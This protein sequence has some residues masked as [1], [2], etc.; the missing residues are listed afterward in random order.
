M[1]AGNT[2]SLWNV[3]DYRVWF[4]GDT[5]S[6]IGMFISSFAM[7]LLAFKVT[8][9]TAL[10]GI[11]S[12][13]ETAFRAI[14]LLFGG[15]LADTVN[16]RKLMLLAACSNVAVYAVLLL[17]W[18][19]GGLTFSSLVI[20]VAVKGILSGV[21]GKITN[22]ILPMIVPKKLLPR[23]SSANQTR[24]AAIDLAS[25]PVG[26]ALF[27]IL[28]ILPFVISFIGFMV[29]I[30]AALL[31]RTN[32]HPK[33][34]KDVS[35]QENSGAAKQEEQVFKKISAGVRWVFSHNIHRSLFF[36]FFLFNIC[37]IGV[38]TSV[39][40]YLVSMGT[41]PTI[42]GIVNSFLS[43]GIMIGGFSANWLQKRMVGGKIV[44]SA[45]IWIVT[46]VSATAISTNYWWL[47]FILF[48]ASLALVP[49][50]SVLQSYQT[51]RTP[52]N[53]MGRMVSVMVLSSMLAITVGTVVSGFLLQEVGFHLTIIIFGCVGVMSMVGTVSSMEIRRIPHEKDLESVTPLD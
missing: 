4:L 8:E 24:D 17:L 32:L 7:V 41:N 11:I 49:M 23:A 51:L 10:A 20:L 9:D 2:N 12:A 19:M 45:V 14:S 27:G 39:N 35:H 44:L 36:I 15:V 16:R 40:L 25:G 42:I 47:G 22:V 6:E 33:S 30:F 34:E 29:E 31:I 50:N 38:I 43:C 53:M 52:N 3:K 48:F 1:Q 13:T 46:F 28:P 18:G 26:G 21:L 5:A 37:W